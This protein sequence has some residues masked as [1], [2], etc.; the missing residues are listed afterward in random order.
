[1]PITNLVAV[2]ID[3]HDRLDVSISHVLSPELDGV[4]DRICMSPIFMNPGVMGWC[5]TLQ[6]GTWSME[7]DEVIQIKSLMSSCSVRRFVYL[8]YVHGLLFSSL[9]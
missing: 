7:T 5:E 2:A 6:M 3:Y 8:I 1:M 4:A 9:G